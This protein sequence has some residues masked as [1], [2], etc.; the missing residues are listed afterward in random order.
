MT[1]SGVIPQNFISNKKRKEK[2]LKLDCFLNI[3]FE[4]IFTA[5]LFHLSVSQFLK[6]FSHYLYFITASGVITTSL[7]MQIYY[8]ERT[9][10][11][12]LR[13]QISN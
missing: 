8:G 2:A 13:F 9:Q 10:I 3:F 7:H 12:F 4:K 11:L 5:K 6:C 1:N